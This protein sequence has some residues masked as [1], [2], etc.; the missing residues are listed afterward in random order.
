MHNNYTERM[1]A[2]LFSVNISVANIMC[3]PNNYTECT[4][5]ACFSVNISVVIIMCTHYNYTEHKPVAF[6][7]LCFQPSDYFS[8]ICIFFFHH[9]QVINNCSQQ[10]HE[11]I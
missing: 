2:A 5:A 3:T 1:P 9:I 4:P 10:S 11:F 8:C 7:K 6:F